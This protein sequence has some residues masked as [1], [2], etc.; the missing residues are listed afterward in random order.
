MTIP[1]GGYLTAAAGITDD[2]IHYWPMNEASGTDIADVADNGPINMDLTVSNDTADESIVDGKFTYA[3]NFEATVANGGDV[4]VNVDNNTYSPRGTD[5]T[6]SMWWKMN[7]L[8][9]VYHTIIGSN[10]N[11]SGTDSENWSLQLSLSEQLRFNYP[12]SNAGQ[13]TSSSTFITDVWYHICLVG[14]SSGVELFVNNVSEGS[15]ATTLSLDLY[16]VF[17]FSGYNNLCG[18]ICDV[19]IWER[20]FDATDRSRIYSSG[21]GIPII[22]PLERTILES[23]YGDDT[24]EISAWVR[25][26]IETLQ[27]SETLDLP[28]FAWVVV[29][30]LIT[31]DTV[32]SQAIHNLIAQDDISLQD[33]HNLAFIFSL[34][35]A[36]I[37]DDTSLLVKKLI[38]SLLEK[39]DSSAILNNT[40]Y[41]ENILLEAS[42]LTDSLL[43]F[44]ELLATESLDIGHSLS[45][46]PL[47]YN[48]LIEE[49][50]QSDNLVSNY[51]F[52][53]IIE[54]SN[55]FS[56]VSSNTGLLNHILEDGLISLNITPSVGGDTYNGWVMNP[57][58]FSVW[59]YEDFNFNSFT[60]FNGVAL[61]AADGGI[62][63]LNSD[64]DDG[65]YIEAKL[66]T[67]AL[68]FGSRNIKQ[69]PLSYLGLTSDGKIV[70]KV[71]VDN[72]ADV[73]YEITPVEEYEHT[74]KIPIGKGLIGRNWQFE[75][76][77]IDNGSLDIENIEFYPVIFKRKL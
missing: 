64:T 40:L 52:N 74:R 17:Y 67:A 6:I 65:T 10:G 60:K 62:Y 8:A 37:I 75:I 63:S 44:F 23:L 51:G 12:D 42:N 25:E 46:D 13:F 1:L 59:N 26:L 24:N 29:E 36:L 56:D 35:E 32:G 28:G 77:T 55:D 30:E 39:V 16:D 53:I 48:T 54:E 45:I 61:G 69:V 11:Q 58:T 2:L 72:K 50:D 4:Q 43:R 15:D 57:E 18:S 5:W 76:V 71:R 33:V 27:F 38:I 73:W 68:D 20:D 14:S 47:L 34:I 7:T 70:L 49:I 41:A 66:T 22:D 21:D 3:R 31:S 19:G 9:T